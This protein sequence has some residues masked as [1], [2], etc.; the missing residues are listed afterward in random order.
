MTRVAVIGQVVVDE[1]FLGVEG[2]LDASAS[3]PSSVR[4]GG[5]AFNIAAAASRLGADV[6]LVTAIGNDS[7]GREALRKIKRL[8]IG[9]TFLVHCSLGWSGPPIPTPRLAKGRIGRRGRKGSTE[10]EGSEN[11]GTRTPRVRLTEGRYRE[12]EVVLDQDESIQECYR[13]ACNGFAAEAFDLIIFTL[14][15]DDQVLA[16]LDAIL[17]RTGAL[18]AANPAP[19]RGRALP[20]SLVAL[21]R[22]A[23]ILTPNR[24][25]ADYLLSPDAD[26]VDAT[27][28]AK[29]VGEKFGCDWSV[30]TMSGEGWAWWES[31]TERSGAARLASLGLADKVGASDVFT[32][33][34]SLFRVWGAGITEA[35]MAAGA[36]ARLAVARTGGAERFPTVSELAHDL[37]RLGSPDADSALESMS[38]RG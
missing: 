32:A 17:A 15:F 25:E 30:V 2:D 35:C 7:P 9:H 11:G 31:D 8:G 24:Y 38:S 3:H 1:V 12:R 28:V 36:A 19:R 18:I 13:T 29:A 14:E 20:K 16:D 21:L 6:E 22:R 10:N 26:H 23:Q 33:T 34:L 27:G 37:K 4:V 5:K